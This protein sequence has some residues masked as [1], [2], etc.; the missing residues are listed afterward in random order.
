MLMRTMTDVTIV[1]KSNN[2]KYKIILQDIFQFIPLNYS[3][4]LNIKLKE[5]MILLLQIKSANCNIYLF[6]YKL[7]KRT[8][9]KSM[10]HWLSKIISIQFFLSD[11]PTLCDFVKFNVLLPPIAYIP[12]LGHILTNTQSWN[13]NQNLFSKM[14]Y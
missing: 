5:S 11:T 10:L 1:I 2:V 13:L 14:F 8:L 3:L 6:C 9:V 7:N 12:I 4:N